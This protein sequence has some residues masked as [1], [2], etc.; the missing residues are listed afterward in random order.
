M[1]QQTVLGNTTLDNST[2]TKTERRIAKLERRNKRKAD[3]AAELKLR[4]EIARKAT[5]GCY[6]LKEWNKMG[7]KVLRG[8]KHYLRN[9][10]NEAVFSGKQV[11]K[12]CK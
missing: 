10:F 9:E 7:Y 6:T 3:L 1:K 5:K 12:T 8:S 2:S 11:Q 4:A